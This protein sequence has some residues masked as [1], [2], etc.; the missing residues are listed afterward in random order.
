MELERGRG[1]NHLGN[2]IPGI[3]LSQEKDSFKLGTE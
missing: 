1:V 3:D 2:Y